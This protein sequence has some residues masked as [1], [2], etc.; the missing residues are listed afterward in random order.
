MFNFACIAPHPPIIIP[1]IGR[2]QDL[3]SVKGTIRSLEKLKN[4]FEKKEIDSLLIVSP[5][6]PFNPS[7]FT[8]NIKD[9][10][11]GGF[12]DF[13]DFKTQ[14]SFEGDID[15][16]K[17]IL[18]SSENVPI[19]QTNY[20]LLDHGTLVPLYYLCKNK[21]PKIII[22]NYCLLESQIHFKFGKVLGE[23]SQN[24]ENKIGIVASGDL[25]HRLTPDA[26]AGFSTQGREF[27]QKL[28]KLL[29]K[30][31]IEGILNIDK[32]LIEEA[33]ECGYKSI[34]ILLG[35]LSTLKNQGWNF[36]ILNYE[37]PFGVGYLTCN[38]RF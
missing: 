34:I 15:L 19:K 29:E 36:E 2:T 13:G 28:I 23:I 11:I 33:G 12:S 27:D 25:S 24:S 4:I 16:A 9:K 31:D 1:T 3:K 20:P 26:P 17:K 5:H 21:K 14:I 7:F 6:S 35:A 10:F 37:G 30:K 18:S 8:L 38:V 22:L 32:D